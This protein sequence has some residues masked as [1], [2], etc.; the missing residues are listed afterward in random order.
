MIAREVHAKTILSKSKVFDCTVN[1]YIGCERG[2]TY[3][4]T[5]FKERYTDHTEKWDEFV[6]AKINA[7][8]LLARALPDP[9]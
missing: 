7:P 8:Y 2:C 9:V 3:C 6:H 1:P 4:Y 5:K